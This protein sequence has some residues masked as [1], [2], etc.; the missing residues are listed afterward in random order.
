MIAPNGQARTEAK[1][2]GSQWPNFRRIFLKDFNKCVNMPSQKPFFQL[3][4]WKIGLIC[5]RLTQQP[6]PACEQAQTGK[7]LFVF[8]QGFLSSCSR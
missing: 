6:S 3:G 4:Q 7:M 5:T 2:E 1:G 8:A